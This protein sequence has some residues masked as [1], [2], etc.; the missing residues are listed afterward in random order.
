MNKASLLQALKLCKPAIGDVG[1]IPGLEC[2]YFDDAEVTAYNGAL[3]IIGNIGFQF[4][5][6]GR[7]PGLTFFR[8]INELP[9]EI[10]ITGTK[11]K[12]IPSILVNAGGSKSTFPVTATNETLFVAPPKTDD[13]VQLP[14][15]AMFAQGIK[16]CMVSIEGGME[17]TGVSMFER[18]GICEMYAS[19]GRTLSR[20]EFPLELE[21][22]GDKRARGPL[23]CFIPAVFC[24]QFT[25]LFAELLNCPSRVT[26]SGNWIVAL[27]PNVSLYCPFYAV[28]PKKN[29]RKLF[30]DYTEGVEMINIPKTL[31]DC[32]RR[33]EVMAGDKSTI[34]I[35]YSPA[36]LEISAIDIGEIH[37]SVNLPYPTEGRIVVDVKDLRKV[38]DSSAQMGFGDNYMLLEGSD[39]I[40]LHCISGRT[41]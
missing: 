7:I 8:L 12:D 33:C 16:R 38:I 32:L 19:N 2:Y 17:E 26:I 30:I 11:L 25:Y 37:E 39:K 35:K 1:V 23:K 40:F 13:D 22:I 10:D 21:S 5:L 14:T 41:N 4:P 6:K 3:A 18:D 9:D 15:S 24:E 31:D 20:Y 29:L 36:G 34:E 28:E 27:F